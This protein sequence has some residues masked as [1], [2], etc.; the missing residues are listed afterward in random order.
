MKSVVF[1]P[2]NHSNSTSFTRE[3]AAKTE[4]ELLPKDTPQPLDCCNTHFS[5]PHDYV[6]HMFM[7]L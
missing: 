7:R 4:Y 5:K 2:Y 6:N 3:T 1:K